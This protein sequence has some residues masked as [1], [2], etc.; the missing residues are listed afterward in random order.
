[1][2]VSTDGVEGTLTIDYLEKVEAL[3]RSKR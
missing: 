1:V 2:I 3:V